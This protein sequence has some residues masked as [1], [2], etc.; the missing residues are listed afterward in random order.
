MVVG[1]FK[2]LSH[3]GNQAPH[4]VPTPEVAAGCPAVH[5]IA[6]SILVGFDKHSKGVVSGDVQCVFD[7]E[8]KSD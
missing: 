7:P 6:R 8:K 5:Q 2:E 3:C 1:L 4:P